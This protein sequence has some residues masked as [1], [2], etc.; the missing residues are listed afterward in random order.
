MCVLSKN[1]TQCPQRVQGSNQYHSLQSAVNCT[2]HE[3]TL[4]LQG[5]STCT[6]K[7][8]PTVH[9]KMGLLSLKRDRWDYGRHYMTLYLPKKGELGQKNIE[10]ETRTEI[11]Q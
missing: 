4:P 10:E 1:T 5:Y 3:V 7:F 2:N 9:V 8:I 6:R 11:P